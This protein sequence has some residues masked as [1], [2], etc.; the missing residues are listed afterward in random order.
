MS[1]RVK[2]LNFRAVGQT[3]AQNDTFEKPENKRQVN[4]RGHWIATF[5]SVSTCNSFTA[6]IPSL[7]KA[8]KMQRN[9]PVWDPGKT[10]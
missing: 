2:Q 7:D 6:R 5:V 10:P 9:G 3:H 4:G 8:Y 1:R